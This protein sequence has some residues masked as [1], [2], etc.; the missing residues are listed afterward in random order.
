MRL[1]GFSHRFFDFILLTDKKWRN[2]GALGTE[3][4]LSRLA[5]VLMGEIKKW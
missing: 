2:K 5:I 4:E 3:D 1:T